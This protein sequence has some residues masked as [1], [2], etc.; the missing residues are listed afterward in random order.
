MFD[1][2]SIGHRMFPFIRPFL[3]LRSL[4]SLAKTG[5]R[6]NQLAHP[7]TVSE[8]ML[9]MGIQPT[10]ETLRDVRALAR[11][12][13]PFLAPRGM[14]AAAPRGMRAPA[15]RGEEPMMRISD[16]GGGF[17]I[18]PTA[19][20]FA[21]ALYHPDHDTPVIRCIIAEYG[22]IERPDRGPPPLSCSRNDGS[23]A[24]FFAS[25]ARNELL[26]F[27][28]AQDVKALLDANVGADPEHFRL[29]SLDDVLDDLGHTVTGTDRIALGRDVRR[30]VTSHKGRSRPHRVVNGF[31]DRWRVQYLFHPAEKEELV[32]AVHTCLRYR[33]V[34]RQV[35]ESEGPILVSAR[36]GGTRY[37]PR[38]VDG[39]PDPMPG[40]VTVFAEVTYR[41]ASLVRQCN[42]Y[43]DPPV[44]SLFED[45]DDGEFDD[46]F[47]ST[48]QWTYNRLFGDPISYAPKTL[49]ITTTDPSSLG[50][51]IE[52][53]FPENRSVRLKLAV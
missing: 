31:C 41:V 8:I 33:M 5:F 32:A 15:P 35:D 9:D 26:N 52:H 47:P 27:L 46:F 53:A 20:L 2:G 40:S 7:H 25:D 10:R 45:F 30:A 37:P 39:A 34:D 36:Y 22:L 28:T 21:E 12:I 49:V 51:V 24:G 44:D 11:S 18:S 38:G 29:L 17:V 50:D 19:Q 4:V 6:M 3:D 16:S 1:E 43:F 42:G 48:F 23:F 13:L 14:R